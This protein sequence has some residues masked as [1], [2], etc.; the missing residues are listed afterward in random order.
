MLS[1]TVPASCRA[2]RLLQWPQLLLSVYSVPASLWVQS[3][4][5][6]SFTV[7]SGAGAHPCVC[8]VVME[9]IVP[10]VCDF[11]IGPDPPGLQNQA[12]E[13]GRIGESR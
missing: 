7:L 10:E 6:T 5:H 13:T 11:S 4:T 9:A 8:G 12:N 1:F 3:H 2:S